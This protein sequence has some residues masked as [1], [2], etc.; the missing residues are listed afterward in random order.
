MAERI[1]AWGRWAQSLRRGSGSL[2]EALPLPKG[3][4]GSEQALM[5]GKGHPVRSRSKGFQCTSQASRAQ[6]HR[7]TSVW[8]TPLAKSQS[9]SRLL[10]SQV[11]LE[12][13]TWLP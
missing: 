1:L 11:P 7:C 6:L 4:T 5:H 10:R 13:C 9:S 12:G 8:C 3:Q 2:V